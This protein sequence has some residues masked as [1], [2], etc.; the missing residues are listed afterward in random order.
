M[1]WKSGLWLTLR[2]W[3]IRCCL[4]FSRRRRSEWWRKSRGR[5]RCRSGGCWR[6]WWP[7]WAAS[8]T[9]CAAS[10][11]TGCWPWAPST[12][13][14]GTASARTWSRPSPTRPNS[15]RSRV[16]ARSSPRTGSNSATPSASACP[17]AGTSP[18]QPSCSSFFFLQ[19]TLV[20]KCPLSLV[21]RVLS[22]D[23]T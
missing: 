18:F 15:A 23:L 5:R 11:A 14:S 20:Q 13:P 21:R 10:C 7:C 22:V 2:G 16:A 1:S 19:P 17:G 3:S 6:A 12:N 8:R 4:F 9:R